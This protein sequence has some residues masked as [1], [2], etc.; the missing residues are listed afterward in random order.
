MNVLEV[1]S[2]IRVFVNLCDVCVLFNCLMW[3]FFFHIRVPNLCS[4]AVPAIINQTA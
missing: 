3:L 4:R 2:L 1:R